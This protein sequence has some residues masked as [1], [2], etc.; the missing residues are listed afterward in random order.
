MLALRP[1]ADSI[2]AGSTFRYHAVGRNIGRAAGTRRFDFEPIL[3]PNDVKVI[4]S[5]VALI[6]AAILAYWSGSPIRPDFS[7]Y[8]MITAVFMVVAMWIFAEAGVKKGDKRKTR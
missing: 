2:R 4:A 5:A 1:K 8:I 7:T 3:M 6:V